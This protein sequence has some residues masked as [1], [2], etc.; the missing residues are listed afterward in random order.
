MYKTTRNVMPTFENINAVNA[1]QWS[2]ARSNGGFCLRRTD[3]LRSILLPLLSPYLF[4]FFFDAIKKNYLH[5]F[6]PPFLLLQNTNTHKKLLC[7]SSFLQLRRSAHPCRRR[8]RLVCVWIRDQFALFYTLVK[9][10]NWAPFIRF[11]LM[12]GLLL[13]SLYFVVGSHFLFNF[14]AKVFH[15]QKFMLTPQ[16]MCTFVI[17]FFFSFYLFF[18]LFHLYLTSICAR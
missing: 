16:Y 3:R 8:W 18:F 1:R 13:F 4:C 9:W 14:I 7:F 5:F 15:N 11:T 2:F 17:V 12:L 10:E 6:S